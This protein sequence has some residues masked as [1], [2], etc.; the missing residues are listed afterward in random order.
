MQRFWEG[1]FASRSGRN[2]KRRAVRPGLEALEDRQL[3]ATY[4]VLNT[5]D[6]GPDSLRSAIAKANAN[7]GLDT[8]NFRIGAGVRTISPLSALPDVT[9]SVII[10][11]TTQPGFA[12]HP[13]IELDGSLAG[14]GGGVGTGVDGLRLLA[15]LC[16]VKGLVINRFSGDG[17]ELLGADKNQLQGNYLGTDV[18]GRL[19]RGNGENGVFIYGGNKNTIGGTTTAARNLISGNSAVGV[20]ILGDSNGATLNVVLGNF[21]G[22]NLAGTAALGNGTGVLLRGANNTI[23][24]TVAGARNVISGNQGSGVALVA[25]LSVFHDA[26]VG[27]SVVGNYIGTTATG[28]AAL[29]NGTGVSL[30]GAYSNTIG[31]TTAAARNVI[32]GN[33]G[34]GVEIASFDV[35]PASNNWVQGNYIGTT[36]AGTG[37]LGNGTGVSLIQQALNN[38]IGGTVAGAGNLI[39]GN[40]GAGVSMGLNSILVTGIPRGNLVQGNSIGTDVTGTVA[41]HNSLG[42]LI[43]AGTQNIIGGVEGARNVISGNS[44]SGVRIVGSAASGN[45]VVGNF[46]GT[47]A[48]G[49]AALGNGTGVSIQDA[50]NNTVGGKVVTESNIISGNGGDGVDLIGSGATGNHVVGNFIGTNAAGTAALGNAAGVLVNGAPNNAIGGLG[51]GDINVISGNRGSG[52]V[53]TGA[54]ATGNQ[55]QNNFIGTSLSL[56]ALGNGSHGVLVTALASNNSIGGMPVNAA[57]TIA[58][59]EGAGVFVESGTGNAILSNSIFSNAG[60]GIDLGPAGVTPNDFLDA[61]AGA[62]GLQNAPVLNVAASDVQFISG[63]LHSKPNATFTLQ[64]FASPS[65]DPSGFGEGK[66]Y[67]GFLTVMTDASGN[68]TF[69]FSPFFFPAFAAGDWISATATDAANNTSEFSDS[70]QAGPIL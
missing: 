62:N 49:N 38:T 22:T 31:G 16:T 13:I 2:Q 50:A 17:I 60:L 33:G 63:K 12:G 30:S 46:I 68:A 24:G 4:T 36:A 34:S 53:L 54:M 9:D 26:A 65:A 57:N 52:V 44:N 19:A 32:S 8:I 42:V 67:I 21:I 69:N 41:L 64:F 56:G 23:G 3:L 51:G 45:S 35:L 18:T 10:D 11:G 20:Y 37:A 58:F 47:T 70:V 6:S 39:A 29:G 48:A 14:G 5:N 55:V 40:S 25:M 61:D 28:F 15:N 43:T 7:P 59:N 1:P 66:L 27:N